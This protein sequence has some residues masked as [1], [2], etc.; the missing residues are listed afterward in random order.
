MK[1][2]PTTLTL[3]QLYSATHEQYVPPAYQRRYSWHEKQVWDL[4]DDIVQLEGSDT[5]LLGSIVC[6]TSPHTAGLARL[7]LVDGQQRLT[8]IGILLH[9]LQER[10]ADECESGVRAR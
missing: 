10:L 7:D 5:H 3:N 6:L 1:I 8:S 2:T 4:I 9:C